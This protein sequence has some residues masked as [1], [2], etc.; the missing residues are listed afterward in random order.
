MS[1]LSEN[2]TRRAL[3]MAPSHQHRG[4]RT[5]RDGYESRIEPGWDGLRKR[6]D[7]AARQLRISELRRSIHTC[8]DGVIQ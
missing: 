7:D 2:P 4:E 8:D 5:S 1:S 3:E 6:L